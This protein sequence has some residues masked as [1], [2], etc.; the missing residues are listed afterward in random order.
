MTGQSYTLEDFQRW[1]ETKAHSSAAWLRSME[2]LRVFAEDVFIDE[3]LV[4]A[5]CRVATKLLMAFKLEQH[6]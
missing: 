6:A 1:L 2:P 3:E 4:I 5:E